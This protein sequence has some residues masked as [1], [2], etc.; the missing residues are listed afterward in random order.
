M[1]EINNE[2]K[3]RADCRDCGRRVG[4][5]VSKKD[6]TGVLQDHQSI[7]IRPCVGSGQKVTQWSFDR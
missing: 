2:P 7:S 5:I 1:R 3:P 6:R 4:V